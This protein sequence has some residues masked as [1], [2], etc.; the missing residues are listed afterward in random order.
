MAERKDFKIRLELFA[1]DNLIWF[2]NIAVLIVFV[3]ANPAM[4]SSGNL[5]GSLYSVSMVGFLVFAQAIVLMLGM[6]DMSIGAIAAFASTI[7]GLTYL[8]WIPGMPWFLLIVIMVIVGA[9]VGLYNGLMISR[10]G[11]NSFLQTL[12]TY[13][14]LYGLVILLAGKTLFGLPREFLAAGGYYIGGVSGVPLAVVLLL[15]AAVV[16]H[17]FLSRI[18]LGRKILAVG[19]NR[20]AAKSVGINVNRSITLTFVIS[21]VLAALA[22]LI[23]TGYMGSIPMSMAMPDL[24]RSFAGAIIGGVSMQGGRGKISGVM[25]GI[26]LLGIL[27]IGLALMDVPPQ[28]REAINGAVL[29]MA[30][31]V[32]TFE[33]KMKARLL[34]HISTHVAEQP[35]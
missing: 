13:I 31:L 32:N 8:S 34:T 27:E 21:G 26:A 15:V 19:S 3:L 10:V 35:T 29:V 5:I 28:S 24:F 18:P 14:L 1:V 12:G 7:A 17:L 25:G 9:G 2:I 11:V 20:L 16:L 6:V 33:A 23:Y 4:I 30:I 22:G